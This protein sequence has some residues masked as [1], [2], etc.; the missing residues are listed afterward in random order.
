MADKQQITGSYMYA[1]LKRAW[2][3]LTAPGQMF[4]VHTVDIRGVPTRA[5][6]HAPA[7]LRDVWMAAAGHATADYLIFEDER[8]SYAEAHRQAAALAA[9][10]AAMGVVPGD[11]VAIAMRNYPEW[12]MAY[13]AITAMGAVV[14]GMNAWW[15]AHE[16]AFALQ[17]SAPKVL[18]AD[19]ERLQ[20]FDEIRSDFAAM[21]AIAVRAEGVAGDWSLPW[22][23]ATDSEAE[24][25]PVDIDPDCGRLYLLYIRY[26]GETQGRPADAPRLC[27]QHHE[28]G[29]CQRRAAAGARLRRGRGARGAGRG[30]PPARAPRDAAVPCHGEQLRGPGRDPRRRQPDPHVQVGRAPGTGDY[31]AGTHHD[32]FRRADDDPRNH[33]AS[34]FRDARHVLPKDDRRRRC[35]D[36]AG[37]RRQG[38]RVHA[39]ARDRTRVTG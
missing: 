18:I 36:A 16:M 38:A 15:V 25:P 30:R 23:D 22:E 21:Q 29:L 3:E 26:H 39:R 28:R 11:R 6:I 5:Y 13:W 24:L 33:D 1:E 35:R 17:D 31:R 32:V 12:M 19:R 20:R 10:L 27:E 9:T 14:V 8:I 34:G 7:S 4:E 2:A 37:S